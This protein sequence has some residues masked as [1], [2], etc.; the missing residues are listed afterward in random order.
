[1]EERV[2]VEEEGVKFEI[3]VVR[4]AK[5][6]AFLILPLSTHGNSGPRGF[7]NLLDK[8]P[9]L[10]GI[11]LVRKNDGAEKRGLQIGSQEATKR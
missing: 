2:K 6:P 9:K 3:P 11:I 1:M 5:L 8:R 4:F 7:G 10:F